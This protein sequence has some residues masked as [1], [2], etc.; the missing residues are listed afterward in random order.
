M[1]REH[2]RPEEEKKSPKTYA[3]IEAG[4]SE[5][6]PS[7]LE[8]IAIY[9]NQDLVWLFVGDS[10]PSNKQEPSSGK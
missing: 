1:R 6:K 2:K 10:Q 9:T 8:K 4:E 5:P 3:K 7:V